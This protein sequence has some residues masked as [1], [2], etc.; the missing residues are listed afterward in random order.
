M[1]VRPRRAAAL[2]VAAAAFGLALPGVASAHS[3]ASTIALDVRLRVE[4]IPGV[5]ATV[6][7][8]NR[9]LRLSVDPGVSLVVRGLLGEPVLRFGGDGVWVNLA[10]PTTAADRITSRHGSGWSRLTRGRSFAWHDHRLAPPRGLPSGSTA[11]FALPVFLNGAP[12]TIGGLFTSVARPAWWPWLLGA[13]V[14]LAAALVL[15]RRAPASRSG[16]AWLAAVAAAVGALVS[17]IGFAT[18]GSLG[19]ASQWVQVGCSAV[20]VV[21]SALAALARHSVRT[22]TASL[23]GA[24]AVVLSLRAVVVFWHGVVISSL[25]PTLTRL[26][27]AAAVAGGLAAA[28]VSFAADDADEPL[29]VAADDARR[30]QRAT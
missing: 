20:L 10:S 29:S 9:R 15:A 8:G 14:A 26:A 21:L 12:R 16:L 18:A 28:G 5:R 19:G 1:S 25:S 22:W 24:A 27:V 17:S 4:S 30:P 7:D 11:P 6:I 23:I 3:R 2:L 13:V